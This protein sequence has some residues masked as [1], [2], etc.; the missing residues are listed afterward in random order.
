MHNRLYISTLTGGGNL[1]TYK[2][3]HCEIIYN[4]PLPMLT[5]FILN[6]YSIQLTKPGYIKTPF[7]RS[8]WM[9]F[10]L[11]IDSDKISTASYPVMLREVC[12][13]AN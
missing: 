13:F 4:P 5:F 2:R 7:A 8:V 9:P 3:L 12:K 11:F 6:I 1:L 10:R